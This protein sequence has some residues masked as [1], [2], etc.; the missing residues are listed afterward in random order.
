MTTTVNRQGRA[1]EAVM[2]VRL[3]AEKA[4][5]PHIALALPRQGQGWSTIEFEATFEHT[6]ATKPELREENHFNNI[7]LSFG[8]FSCRALPQPHF[9]LCTLYCALAP[10]CVQFWRL[11]GDEGLLNNL[12]KAAQVID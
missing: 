12:K 10:P 3:D 7:S 8:S 4:C 6:P 5:H 1:D 9:I 2:C 11:K